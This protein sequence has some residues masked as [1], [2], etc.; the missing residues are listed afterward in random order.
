[1]TKSVLTYAKL[2]AELSLKDLAGFIN[3]LK[4]DDALLQIESIIATAEKMI[5]LRELNK[6]V[7]IYSADELDQ[8]VKTILFEKIQ[9]VIEEPIIKE[10]KD[11]YLLAGVKVELPGGVIDGSLLGRLN[12]LN[13]SLKS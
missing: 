12:H 6:T 10:V 8:E 9:S 5:N 11:K 4:E 13:A 7:T 3:L 1:M 2:L